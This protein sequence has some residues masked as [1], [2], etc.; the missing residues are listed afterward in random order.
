MRRN[1]LTVLLFA[2]ALAVQAFAPAAAHVATRMGAGD[3]LS[4]FCVTDVASSDQSQAPDHAKGHRDVCLFCQN[5]CDGVA[6]LAA[7]VIFLGK[8]P[9]QW[10]ALDW[11]VADRALPTPPLDYS[12]QAR[13]PPANS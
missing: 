2:L 8:A 6:P 5:H 11:T 9:V 12:R 7:R 1:W 13:A 10:T 3:F 4:E